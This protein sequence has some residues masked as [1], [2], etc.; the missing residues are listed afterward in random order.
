DR[1]AFAGIADG[2]HP[3]FI[4]GQLFRRRLARREQV[5]A[6]DVDGAESGTERQH[7]QDR[8]PAV[9]ATERTRACECF[10]KPGQRSRVASDPNDH[11]WWRISP[12]PE[13]GNAITLTAQ[14]PAPRCERSA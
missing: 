11:L 5:R 1:M 7:D 2:R 13:L 8:N 6:N 3:A 4:G 9:H 10:L 14:L 12:P